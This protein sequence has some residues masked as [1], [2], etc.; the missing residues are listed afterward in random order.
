MNGPNGF[1]TYLKQSVFADYFEWNKSL[2]LPNLGSI[3]VTAS[4]MAWRLA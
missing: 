4:Y 1:L 2:V 3:F